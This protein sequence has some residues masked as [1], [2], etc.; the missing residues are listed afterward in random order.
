M[1]IS[2]VEGMEKISKGCFEKNALFLCAVLPLV[3]GMKERKQKL[4]H[5]MKH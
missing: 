3:N 4:L 1:V 2:D 5:E